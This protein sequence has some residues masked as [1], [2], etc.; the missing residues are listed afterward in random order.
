MV[1]TYRNVLIS[2][3]PLFLVLYTNGSIKYILLHFVFVFHL[4]LLGVRY[5]K[6]CPCSL[7][8]FYYPFGNFSLNRKVAV[9]AKRMPVF[10][11]PHFP[12]QQ[13]ATPI[14]FSFA[15]YIYTHDKVC[16]SP[17]PFKRKLQV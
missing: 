13:L 15:L 4:I 16:F 10:P 5:Y 3:Y 17:E 1:T 11:L 6:E 8:F 2:H 7:F 9:V 12:T 14:I